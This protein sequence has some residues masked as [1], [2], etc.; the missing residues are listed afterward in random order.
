MSVYNPN[1]GG[2]GSQNLQQ[3]TDIGSVTTN[4]IE[5]T[6]F[7]KTG[8]SSV[9]F[10]KADGSVDTSVYL[11]LATPPSTLGEIPIYDP[12]FGWDL[13]NI[14]TNTQISP[15]TQFL[16]GSIFSK[17]SGNTLESGGNNFSAGYEAGRN[18]TIGEC[19][20]NIG[21]IAGYG[22]TTGS[23][24]TFIGC[25]AG[26]SNFS[27]SNN[28]AIGSYVD[29]VNSN[30]NNQLNI[31]NVLYGTGLY[32]TA[33]PSSTPVTTGK[34]GIGITAPTQQ[35][36]VFGSGLATDGIKVATSAFTSI[37][38]P[39]SVTETVALTPRGFNFTVDGFTL[40]ATYQPTLGIGMAG[41]RPIM[42]AI[43]A[44]STGAAIAIEQGRIGVGTPTPETPI[45]SIGNIQTRSTGG[46]AYETRTRMTSTYFAGSS[47]YSSGGIEIDGV[48]GGVGYGIFGATRFYAG[49]NT[50]A[51]RAWAWKADGLLG[52]TTLAASNAQMVL[53]KSGNL[54]L[55]GVAGSAAAILEL[56]STTKGLMLPRMTTT[57]RDAITSPGAGLIIFNTTTGVVNFHNGTVWGAV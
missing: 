16:S 11:A 34:I 23:D 25:S 38:N 56:I 5:S 30:G 1:I 2:G 18:L 14:Y 6:G 8:G 57:Q 43:K 13:T 45:D 44:S 49:A 37:P 54:I 33:S 46:S 40:G 27:G 48:Q 26:Y 20:I 17:N 10:L 7:I 35:F 9:E 32:S 53:N 22:T 50:D 39:G 28:I 29:V 55:G 21:Y 47:N 4:T 36:H 19:N 31:G 15:F 3:V 52:T 24:N 12:M 41:N 42:L 51:T